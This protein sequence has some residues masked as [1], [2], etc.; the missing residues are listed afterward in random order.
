MLYW[1]LRS[2]ASL[3]GDEEDSPLMSTACKWFVCV[4]GTRGWPCLTPRRQRRH[5]CAVEAGNGRWKLAGGEGWPQLHFTVCFLV[6]Q[7]VYID[8]FFF[9]YLFR[10]ISLFNFSCDYI[11]GLDLD[12]VFMNYAILEHV[13]QPGSHKSDNLCSEVGIFFTKCLHFWHI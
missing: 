4:Y 6:Q 12:S 10:F 8:Y 5:H 2:A 1:K 13:R 7:N 11:C 9:L 3:G